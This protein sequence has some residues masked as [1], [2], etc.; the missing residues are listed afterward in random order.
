M[1][2]VLGL[3]LFNLFINNLQLGESSEEATFA[4]AARLLRMVQVKSDCREFKKG[5][6]QMG[7]WR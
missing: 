5:L 2:L 1:S 3:L 4:D 6:F 7:K